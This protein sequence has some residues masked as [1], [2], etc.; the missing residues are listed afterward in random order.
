MTAMRIIQMNVGDI[1]L[2]FNSSKNLPANI[3]PNAKINNIYDY[4][5]VQSVKFAV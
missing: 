4:M 1:F 2:L 3:A 5:S